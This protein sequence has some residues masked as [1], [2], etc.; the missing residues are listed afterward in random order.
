MK[1]NLENIEM[2]ARK[3]IKSEGKDYKV[4]AKLGKFPFPIKNYGCITLPAGDYEALRV[5]IGKGDGANWW[6][7]LFPPLCF[8][9]ITHTRAQDEAKLAMSN[10]LTS[11]EMKIIETAEKPKDL[12]FEIRFKLLD[13]WEEAK[14]K[15]DRTIRLAFK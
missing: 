12:P 10:V 15:I 3:V 11:Q 5:V 9:D 14:G 7:V 4:T 6:C 2:I 13:L 8:V 1:S